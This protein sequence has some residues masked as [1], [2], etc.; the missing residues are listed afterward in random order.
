MVPASRPM[1]PGRSGPSAAELNG[2]QSLVFT[3][4]MSP[5]VMQVLISVG[6]SKYA[7]DSRIRHL[8]F[9]YLIHLAIMALI[10]PNA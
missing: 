4:L 1:P 9:F 5:A 7:L 8:Y 2:L 3:V 10:S 6:N